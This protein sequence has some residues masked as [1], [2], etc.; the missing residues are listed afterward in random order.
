MIAK[1]FGTAIAY[2]IGMNANTQNGEKDMDMENKYD[3][4]DI[5]ITTD[6]L[7]GKCYYPQTNRGRAIFRNALIAYRDKNISLMDF[8]EHSNVT[9]EIT[10]N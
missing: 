2:I 3:K 7:G 8:I 6:T 4:S 1:R 9:Y 10:D 5:L